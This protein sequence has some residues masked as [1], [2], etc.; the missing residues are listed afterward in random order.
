M[1]IT[2]EQ[3]WEEIHGLSIVIRGDP[4]KREDLGL[5]GDVKDNTKFRKLTEKIVWVLAIAVIGAWGTIAAQV[6]L[7]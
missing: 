6:L 3:I 5:L 7:N 1:N 4:D 2:N